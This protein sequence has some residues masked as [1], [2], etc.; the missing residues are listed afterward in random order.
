MHQ[1]LDSLLGQPKL[2]EEIPRISLT[3]DLVKVK[4]T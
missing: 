3:W 4:I 1:E 2:G